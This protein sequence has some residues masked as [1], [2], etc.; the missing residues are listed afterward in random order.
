MVTE[1]TRIPF[2]AG[3]FG[4]FAAFFAFFLTG[5]SSGRPPSDPPRPPLPSTLPPPG[6]PPTEPPAQPPQG[7]PAPPPWTSGK[8]PPAPGE[9]PLDLRRVVALASHFGLL[10]AWLGVLRVPRDDRQDVA[11]EVLLYVLR[12]WPGLAF[13][14]ELSDAGSL[15]RWLF[16][17]AVY[18]ASEHRRNRVRRRD[19]VTDPMEH[20]ATAPQLASEEPSAEELLVLRAEADDVAADVDLDMLRAAT[21]PD[22]WAAFFA[23]DVE[24]LS[25]KAIAAAHGVPL[26]TIATRIRLAKEDLRAAILRARARREGEEQRAAAKRKRGGS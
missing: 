22:R 26:G 13:P 11:Q 2:V 15:R 18:K 25:M 5:G 3:I 16:G 1:P 24:G 9:P 8:R 6:E 14:P 23:H 20:G 7:P 19:H 17:A 21:T 4:L 12:R 10:L